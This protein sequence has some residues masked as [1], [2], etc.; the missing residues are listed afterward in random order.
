MRLDRITDRACRTEAVVELLR[1]RAEL[2]AGRGQEVPPALRRAIDD[3]DR[4]HHADPPGL[5]AGRP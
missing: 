2:R 3:F 1:R 5:R 4:H